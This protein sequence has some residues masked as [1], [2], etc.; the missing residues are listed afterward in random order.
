MRVRLRRPTS[1][2]KS[3]PPQAILPTTAFTFLRIKL[4]A[5]VPWLAHGP[6]QPAPLSI[7]RRTKQCQHKP[8]NH[9]QILWTLNRSATTTKAPTYAETRLSNNTYTLQAPSKQRPFLPEPRSKLT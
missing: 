8:S 9:K 1:A 3:F 7:N 5:A 6:K 2:Q 4:C